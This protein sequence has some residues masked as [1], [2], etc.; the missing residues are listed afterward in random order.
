MWKNVRSKCVVIITIIALSYIALFVWYKDNANVLRALHSLSNKYAVNLGK[1]QRIIVHQNHQR[2]YGDG[3][4]R[5]HSVERPIPAS[6]SN[7]H[8]SYSTI[9]R[10][11]TT[12]KLK[13]SNRTFV[14]NR[15][16]R[17]YCNPTGII[18]KNDFHVD[19]DRVSCKPVIATEEGCKLAEKF[20]FHNGKLKTCNKEHVIGDIC[21]HTTSSGTFKCDFGGCKK[22]EKPKVVVWRA[23]NNDTGKLKRY[24]LFDSERFLERSLGDMSVETVK[25]GYGFLILQCVNKNITCLLYTSPSPRDS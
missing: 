11:I 4:L 18:R 10:S 23:D 7:N 20:H 17:E 16:Q 15:R 6:L 13:K 3:T 5:T 24:K 21:K 1:A 25:K 8:A 2:E 14:R 9:D 22:H 19:R 12:S